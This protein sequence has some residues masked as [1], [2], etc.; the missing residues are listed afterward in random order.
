LKMAYQKVKKYSQDVR[1][2]VVVILDDEGNN[3]GMF[4]SEDDAMFYAMMR[5]RFVGKSMLDV[6]YTAYNS[7]LAGGHTTANAVKAGDLA[8][9]MQTSGHIAR[10]VAKAMA[11]V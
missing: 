7:A 1:G 4:M 6:W 11:R 10:V 8:V 9:E 5:E 3:R 2:D